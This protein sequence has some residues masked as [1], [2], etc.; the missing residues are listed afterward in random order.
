MTK[1]VK[2]SAD[3]QKLSWVQLTDKMFNLINSKIEESLIGMGEDRFKQSYHSLE[4]RSSQW[5]TMST[6]QREKH[7]VKVFEK[8][9]VPTESSY[10]C[11]E[12][13]VQ[14]LRILLFLHKS[15]E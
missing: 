4:L 6:Q 1:V 13:I 2:A 8:S 14:V 3:H 9:C 15:Q 10:L 12:L 7:L 5:F 11:G